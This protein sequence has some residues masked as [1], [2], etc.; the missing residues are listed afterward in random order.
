MR[1]GL[2]AVK[3]LAE[4]LG[5]PIA[6]VSLLEAIA[7]VS[8]E[9]RKVIAALDAG[10]QQIYVGE[11]EISGC[12]ASRIS[13]SLKTR[14]EFLKW[15]HDSN[16]VTPSPEIVALVQ[17]A[18]FAVRLIPAPD[19][20]L[21]AA[22]GWRKILAGETVAPESLEANYVSRTYADFSRSGL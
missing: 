12:A 14:D 8:G 11:Y 2:A 20:G 6:A 13:E 22:V 1:V 17:S 19:L 9:K 18:G 16:I 10:R 21:I 4:V 3:A 15:V 7:L 5:K